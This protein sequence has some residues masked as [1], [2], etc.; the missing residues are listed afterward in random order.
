M[1]Y[2]SVNDVIAYIHG[3]MTTNVMSGDALAIRDWLDIQFW[4]TLI[5][6]KITLDIAKAY[7]KWYDLVKTGGPWDH[8]SHIKKTYGDWT[9]DDPNSRLYF[10]DIWSNIHYGYIGKAC[11]FP[12]WDLLAGAGIAQW[13]AGTV[14]DGY[15]ERRLKKIGDAD[16]FSAFDD[17]ADQEA[18]KVGFELW[19][20]RKTTLTTTHILDAVRLRNASLTTK[21]K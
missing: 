10:F 18:I 16:V 7:K 9:L 2:Q 19:D 1:A 11:G 21:P 20:N 15:W 3:E 4:E 17:P 6:G 12:E 13:K 5:P 8:K 14:P